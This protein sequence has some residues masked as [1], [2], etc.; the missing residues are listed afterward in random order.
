M[1]LI[2]RETGGVRNRFQVPGIPAWRSVQGE[3]ITAFVFE[4][5]LCFHRREKVRAVSASA[6]GIGLIHEIGQDLLAST[7]RT[8]TT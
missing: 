8:K 4:T 6:R 1:G 3:A 2:G 5:S 7:P